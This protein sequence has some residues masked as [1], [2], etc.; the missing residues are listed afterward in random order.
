LRLDAT[1]FGRRGHH[2]RTIVHCSTSMARRI[3][4]LLIGLLAMGIG[5]ALLA[6]AT[7]WL[8]VVSVC[9]ADRAP[10]CVAWPAVVSE[11]AWASF[12]LGIAALVVWQ[13]R[14]L[15]R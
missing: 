14:Y 3:G 10:G 6:S 8:G 5:L 13:V 7:G 11:L 9:G 12:V 2:R 4:L 1:G 15:D